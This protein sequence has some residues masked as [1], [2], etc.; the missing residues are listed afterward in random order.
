LNQQVDLGIWHRLSQLVIGLIV[1][2][3]LIACF[4]WYLPV[5]K[6]NAKLRKQILILETQIAAEEGSK[7]QLQAV[8]Q[9]MRTDPKTMERMARQKLGYAKPGETV[10]V[11]EAPRDNIRLI[12]P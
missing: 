1:L 7:A 6:Y 5:F 12:Q 11:F 2:A 10:I 8:I 4:L 3:C 9:N